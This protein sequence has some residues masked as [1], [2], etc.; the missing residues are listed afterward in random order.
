M[1]KPLCWGPVCDCDHF[2]YIMGPR[3]LDTLSFTMGAGSS[4]VP[5]VFSELVFGSQLLLGGGGAAG[6]GGSGHVAGQGLCG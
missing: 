1:S 6:G 3:V 4:N 2:E 5:S